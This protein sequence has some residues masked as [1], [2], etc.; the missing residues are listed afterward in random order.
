MDK[1]TEKRANKTNGFIALFIVIALFALDIFLLSQGIRTEDPSFLWF[2]IPLVFI[3]FISFGGFMIV[4]PNESKVLVLFGKYTGTVRDSGF[5]WVNP[6]TV[7]KHVSL[8]I[9]NFNSDKIKVNDLHGNPIE[10]AAVIVWRVVDSARAIFDVQNYEQFVA[11]Q[12]ETAIRTLASEY[13]YDTNEGEKESLRSSPTE[14]AENLQK[15]LQTRLEVAGVTIV[16]ARITHLAYAQ[17]I[18]QAMLRRQQ[19]QAIVAARFKIVEGAV[20]MVQ[21]ALQ[22]LSDKNIVNLDEER[23]A[24]MVNNL[25]VALVA[26]HEAIPVIN[27]GTIYQ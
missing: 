10:I 6:F 25:M 17:E 11:I 1:I 27:T 20:G 2:F 24:Q 7:K 9:R 23:K 3:S 5:W 12:A 21:Q 19:A 15:E 14:V 18:A 26:D 16:E 8:R 22:D 13:P 4:Q